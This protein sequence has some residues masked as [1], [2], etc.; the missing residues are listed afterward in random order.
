MT[1]FW[2]HPETRQLDIFL[3]IDSRSW[4][5][6]SIIKQDAV[7]IGSDNMTLIAFWL[8]SCYFLIAQYILWIWVYFSL[9]ESFW[10]LFLWTASLV[11]PFLAPTGSQEV[12]LSVR[13]S[14]PL[15]TSCLEQSIFIFSVSNQS[16]ISQQLVS[17][18]SAISQ[19][20]VSH[21]SAVSQLSVIQLV[22]IPSEPKIL[23]LVLK[24][25]QNIS[26]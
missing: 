2:L 10:G 19:Q 12:T 1:Q 15:V 21:Q 6:E 16:T 22:I 3:I 7:L 13:P 4:S 20:L 23:C 14:V 25:T 9:F 8:F 5:V 11:S 24:R 26:P 17:S 18:Q